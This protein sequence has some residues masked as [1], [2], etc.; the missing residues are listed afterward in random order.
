M[1]AERAREVATW[2][3][4][5]PCD[6]DVA[7][8]LDERT[9]LD[10]EHVAILEDSTL[11]GFLAVGVV[12][13]I[14]PDEDEDASTDVVIGIRPD[15]LGERLGTRA[16][17]LALEALGLGGH[18]S[19]RAVVRATDDRALRLALRLGFS[20]TS[21]RISEVDGATFAILTR[22]VLG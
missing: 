2:R 17:E 7:A 11:V 16:G 19:L 18:R 15:R 4:E 6:A 12:T 9:L 14:T 1:T 22:D 3:Y 5:P 8:T 20:P 10:G 21:T 13:T